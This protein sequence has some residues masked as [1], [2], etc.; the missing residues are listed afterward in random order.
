MLSA[1]SFEF[2]CFVRCKGSA[3]VLAFAIHAEKKRTNKWEIG[4][5]GNTDSLGDGIK[6]K[7]K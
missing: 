1:P 7:E 3:L 2:S 5:R 4:T 6:I